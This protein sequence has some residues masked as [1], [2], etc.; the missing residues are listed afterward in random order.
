MTIAEAIAR[1]IK[2]T[3][4]DSFFQLT[5]G[6]QGLWIGLKSEGIRMYLARSEQGATYMADGYARMSGKPGL[7][8]GQQGPGA[9]N[10]ASS[11]AD[12]HWASSPVVA[13]T[14]SVPS[15]SRD[16][17]AYQELDQLGLFS[18]VTKWCRAAY[19]QD[20]VLPM[21]HEAMRAAVSGS[22]GP[23]HLEAPRDLLASEAD[24]SAMPTS[25]RSIRAPLYRLLPDPS[26]V[27]DICQAVAK[28]ERP[29]LL[30]GNGVLIS[31]AWTAIEAVAEALQLPVATTIGGKGAIREN[32]RLA[33]GVAGRYSRRV[34]NEIVCDAD[35]VLAVGSRL[36]ALA[37]SEFT[38]PTRSTSIAHIDIDA[39][40]FGTTY[41]EEFSLLADARLALEAI[42]ENGVA[43]RSSKRAAWIDD[44][45]QR[46]A[47]WR[48]GLDQ[49]SRTA[50]EPIHPAA[51]MAVLGEVLKPTDVVVADTGYMAA[52]TGALYDVLVP[53]RHFLRAAGSLGWALPGALGVKVAAPDLRV[54]CVIGDG[55]VAYNIAELETAVRCGIPVTVVVLNN[56]SLA[57]E[58]HEQ[59]YLWQGR[60]VSEANDFSDADYSGVARALGARGVRVSRLSDLPGALK[61]CLDSNEPSLIDV[62]VDKEAIAPVTNFERV[63]ERSV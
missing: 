21:L 5:G 55:G 13:L 29:V 27:D 3:G 8:Y 31:E 33:I 48:A 9:A 63:L 44:V 28:A 7:V 53:G 10:V 49:L 54:V 20:R 11:L 57:F 24:D 25:V 59:K 45:Q 12:A 14:S 30:A 62:L 46:V 34:S 16:R 19:Q 4:T 32:H 50:G 61:D 26:V 23:V 35:F 43:A 22:P 56:R 36:G 42:A 39:S 58:Y 38:I 40:V 6:D 18:T 60:V 37:T 41:L 17:Y 1:F 2:T 15:T 51:A 52:W 47:T